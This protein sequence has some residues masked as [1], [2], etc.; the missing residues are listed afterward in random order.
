MNLENILKSYV[1][2]EIY[3][4]ELQ[5]ILIKNPQIEN[6][7]KL[8]EEIAPYSNIS[9]TNFDYIISLNPKNNDD[10]LNAQD[11]IS[12]LL[13]NINVQHE[14]SNKYEK[15]SKIKSKVQPKWLDIDMKLFGELLKEAGGMDEK[16]LISW[17]KNKI[18]E[19]YRYENK[20]PKWIQN[21]E[22]PIEGIHPLKFIDQTEI[23]NKHDIEWE[24]KFLNESTGDIKIITQM[25]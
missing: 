14:F 18:L 25:T 7:L 3:L 13:S 4:Q 8:S 15:I 21:P 9:N 20:P 17:I 16:H 1:E 10:C 6:F 23:K 19:K 5:H 24:Y 11:L 2:G 12:Q 22:W